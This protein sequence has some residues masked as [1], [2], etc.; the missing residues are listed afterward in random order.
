MEIITLIFVWIYL[1]QEYCGYGLSTLVIWV[2]TV[3]F[4]ILIGE[5]FSL[6]FLFHS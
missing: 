1:S 5:P 6:E 4:V 2:A 3:D